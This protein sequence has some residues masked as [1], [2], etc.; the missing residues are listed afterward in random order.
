MWQL[1]S[2][3]PALL[4]NAALSS[5]SMSS[6]VI[7]GVGLSMSHRA[8]IGTSAHGLDQLVHLLVVVQGVPQGVLR[9]EQPLPQ[10][11][12]LRIQSHRVQ[13]GVA[14]VIR[15]GSLPPLEKKKNPTSSAELLR[16]G[17]TFGRSKTLLVD[18]CQL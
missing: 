17:Q 11:V 9:A 6:I 12:H 16:S 5:L 14:S 4:R 13:H 10:A 7:I 15:G 18:I 1:S 3:R 8:F 2:H